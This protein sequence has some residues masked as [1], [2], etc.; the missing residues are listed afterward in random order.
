MRREVMKIDFQRAGARWRLLGV[1]L[2][3]A[4]LC[5]LAWTGLQ[6]WVGER[7]AADLAASSQRVADLQRRLVEMRQQRRSHDADS[8]APALS[9]AEDVRL[10]MAAIERAWTKQVALRD[11]SI[12]Q[13]ASTAQL[14]FEAA[15][16][17]DG[18]AFVLALRQVGLFRQVD[19]R[20]HTRM[21]EGGSE[22]LVMSVALDWSGSGS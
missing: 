1:M 13:T 2:L 17:E 11:L 20:R 10:P 8:A 14:E 18:L 22:R 7:Q 16:L 21:A 15:S 3:L 5:L 12:Q 19:L 4:G 6:A 9:P